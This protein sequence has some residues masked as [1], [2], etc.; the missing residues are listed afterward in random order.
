[1][2]KLS[3]NLTINAIIIIS[4]KR[5]L[6]VLSINVVI[7]AIIIIAIIIIAIIILTIIYIL[8]SKQN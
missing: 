7:I 8:N 3:Q 6:Y 4:N 1:M 2:L 5:K